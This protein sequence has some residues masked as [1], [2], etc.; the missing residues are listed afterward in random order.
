MLSYGRKINELVNK[1]FQ[2]NNKKQLTADF[3]KWVAIEKTKQIVKNPQKPVTKAQ[4]KQGKIEEKKV[5]EKG[6]LEGFEVI[7]VV[8][9]HMEKEV[10]E[11]KG[12]KIIKLEVFITYEVK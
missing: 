2:T 7:D 4:K 10:S 9:V 5:E 3:N 6:Q 12:K 8:N 11:K 1:Y